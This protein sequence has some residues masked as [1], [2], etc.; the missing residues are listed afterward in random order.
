MDE[1]R[2]LEIED[3]C[4]IINS[5]NE[6]LYIV[7]DGMDPLGQNLLAG[8]YACSKYHDE[9][10]SEAYIKMKE[11]VN[12]LNNGVQISNILNATFFSSPEIPNYDGWEKACEEYVKIYG[13][14]KSIFED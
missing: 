13:V 1:Y 6:Y 11:I 2:I 3:T 7:I 5:K 9:K 10:E 4:Y 8:K 12:E 14:R